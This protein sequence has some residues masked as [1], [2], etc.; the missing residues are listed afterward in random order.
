V[1]TSVEVEGIGDGE[2]ESSDE[3]TKLEVELGTSED[4]ATGELVSSIDV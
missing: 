4:V 2:I 1:S 3:E